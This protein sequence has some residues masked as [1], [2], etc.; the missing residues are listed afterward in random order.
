V[1][2]ERAPA[3][4][5]ALAVA[6]SAVMVAA[7]TRIVLAAAGG[8]SPIVPASPQ[9]AGWLRHLTGERLS[10]GVFLTGV[11][12]FAAAYAGLVALAR[13][14]STRALVAL[15]ALLYAIVFA[16]PILV[17]TDVFSYIAYAR[18]GV[19][20][21]LNP[22]LSSPFAIRHDAIFPFVGVNWIFVPTA[23]GPLYTL[24]SYPFA[25]LGVAGAVWGM[26]AVALLACAGMDW[27]TWRCARRRGIDPKVAL[28]TVAV[29]PLV[30][31]Y[32]LASA[33][34]D[35]LMIAV[36]LFAVHLTLSRRDAPARL[37]GRGR[38]REA[39]AGAA[40][41]AAALVKVPAGVVLPFM[42]AGR[43]RL[44]AA[45]G[46][47]LA[48]AAG[49]GVAYAAF[50]SPGADILSG[51]SRDSAYVSGD[52]FAAQIAH[53]LGKPG[54]FPVDHAILRTLLVL[55]VIYL[56]AR[57]WRGYDWVDASGWALL[58]AS[59]TSTWLQSWYLLWPLPLA[60][61][62]R[63]RRLLWATLLV[64]ALFVVHQLS[65]LLTPQ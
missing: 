65:P 43:R 60:V 42:V 36:M 31:L 39:L 13:R 1:P 14:L 10:Y 4:Q 59:V 45:L 30:V 15:I 23:Y 37:R 5:L 32:G 50:G 52:S 26:K 63:D 12:A 20:H 3:W 2:T 17:S 61:I 64:Q 44:S 46:G 47:V 11:L 27:L 21:G 41:V 38:G 54:V 48:L 51:A 53:L 28:V 6:C 7:T 34:N 58:G 18:M 16:G 19:L 49:L 56:L 25:A 22:Y 40:V 57:V 55:L 35:L 8:E 62:A 24:L 9:I 29:N 33:Q